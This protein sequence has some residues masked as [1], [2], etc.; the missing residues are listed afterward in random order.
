MLSAGKEWRQESATVRLFIL[1]LT[2]APHYLNYDKPLEE[3]GLKSQ[4]LS[5]W[6]SA[7]A[8]VFL[9]LRRTNQLLT[10]GQKVQSCPMQHSKFSSGQTWHGKSLQEPTP[11][12]ARPNTG[13]HRAT[14]LLRSNSYAG[15]LNRPQETAELFTTSFNFALVLWIPNENHFWMINILPTA[16]CIQAITTIGH[17]WI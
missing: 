7:R 9:S 13:T 17:N 12:T 14:L 2:A 10:K 1:P 5:P 6:I 3:C 15:D 8:I 11:C 4:L 16:L